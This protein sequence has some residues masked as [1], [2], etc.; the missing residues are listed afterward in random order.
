MATG[1]NME[2]TQKLSVCCC[3][4]KGQ[5]SV[6]VNFEK[7]AYTPYETAKCFVD[8][9]N[10]QCE[11]PIDSVT[12]KL[13]RDCDARAGPHHMRI[14]DV[15]LTTASHPGVEAKGKKER[16]HMQLDLNNAR[17]SNRFQL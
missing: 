6:K 17:E 2:N 1:Q 13:M 16:E 15:C 8:I 3:M 14:P 4:D 11:L 10:S 9:D 5:S 7:D 12:F